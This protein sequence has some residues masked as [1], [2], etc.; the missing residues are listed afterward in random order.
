MSNTQIQ[1]YSLLQFLFTTHKLT[2]ISFEFPSF[3]M[4]IILEQVRLYTKLYILQRLITWTIPVCYLSMIHIR[5]PQIS[6][7]KE[8]GTHTFP[9]VGPCVFPSL[10]QLSTSPTKISNTQKH[11]LQLSLTAILHSTVP[12]TQKCM[13]YYSS[14]YFY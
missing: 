10:P 3:L 7:N 6:V 5:M 9:C 1:Q 2:F 13:P 4:T 8:Q 12:F 11:Q 14:P